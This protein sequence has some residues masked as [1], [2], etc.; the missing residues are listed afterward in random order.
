MADEDKGFISVNTPGGTQRVSGVN[1][2][3]LYALILTSRKPEAVE[4]K[5]WVTQQVLPTIRKTGGYMVPSLAVQA[6]EDLA[7]S[8]TCPIGQP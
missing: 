1:E 8:I 7:V 4:F 6:V 2:A 3:G 5:R